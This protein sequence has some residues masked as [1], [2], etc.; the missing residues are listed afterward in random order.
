VRGLVR[1][2]LEYRQPIDPGEPVVLIE[3]SELL[4][5]VVGDE[6]RAALGVYSATP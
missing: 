2:T 1:A 5:L 6:I 4:W 3:G